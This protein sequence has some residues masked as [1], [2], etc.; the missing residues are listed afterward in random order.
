MKRLA[1]RKVV[2][3]MTFTTANP[4]GS[5]IPVYIFILVTGVVL[6]FASMG[7]YSLLVLTPA[8]VAAFLLPAANP[9]SVHRWAFLLQMTWQTL[10]HLWLQYTSPRLENIQKTRF[11]ISISSLMLLTQRVTSVAL[12]IHEGKVRSAPEN[13]ERGSFQQS[14]WSH[15]ALCSYLLFFPALLGGPLCS[16]LMFDEQISRVVAPLANPIRIFGRM[17]I[18]VLVLQMLRIFVQDWVISQPGLAECSQFS[19]VSTMWSTALLFKLSYY[20]HWLLDESLVHAAGFGNQIGHQ[21]EIF[22]HELSD[23]DLWTL[24]TTNRMSLFTRTWNKSTSQWL[25]RLIFKKSPMQPLLV[26]FIFSAWWHGLYPGQVFGFLCWAVMV[27]ADYRI[28]PYLSSIVKSWHATL[29]F[30]L[31]TLVQTQLVVAY[32]MVA[33]EMRSLSVLWMLCG[34]YCSFFPLLNCGL[35]IWLVKRSV[36]T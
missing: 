17:C 3:S 16:F 14:L 1:E 2:I 5:L 19:C 6:S 35:L 22:H 32:I 18:R 20:S 31:L 24:E 29:L 33:V 13:Q 34:S 27:E 26:T 23:M 36:K 9:A 25:R 30:K 12:D 7:P 10:C 4:S 15:L 11:S 21:A 8:F 28:S